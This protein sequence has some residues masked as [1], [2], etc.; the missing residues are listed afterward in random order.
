M[1]TRKPFVSRLSLPLTLLLVASLACALPGQATKT[2]PA[3]E[4]HGNRL[5]REGS[6]DCD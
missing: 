1:G 2:T 4:W 3:W 5:D 6:N